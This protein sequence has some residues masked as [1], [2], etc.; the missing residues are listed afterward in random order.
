MQFSEPDVIALIAAPLYFSKESNG[1]I[2]PEYADRYSFQWGL[3]SYPVAID[4]QYLVPLVT[5]YVEK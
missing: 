1:G 4:G 5:Y 3:A 2:A